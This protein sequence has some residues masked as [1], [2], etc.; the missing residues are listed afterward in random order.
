MDYRALLEE[1][2]ARGLDMAALRVAGLEGEEFDAALKNL[3]G[4]FFERYIE[5]L[6]R[7]LME[8]EA[9]GLR[10]AFVAAVLARHERQQPGRA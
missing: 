3:L 7:P 4:L 10:G 1:R 5:A 8:G 6:K 9:A 2:F